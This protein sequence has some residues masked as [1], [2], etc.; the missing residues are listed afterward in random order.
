[1]KDSVDYAITAHPSI[2]VGKKPVAVFLGDERVPVKKWT[3]VYTVILQRCAQD[4][5]YYERL[6][7]F[8]NKLAGKIRVFIS[9]KPDGMTRQV[10][11]CDGLYGETHYG[12]QTLMH[13][14]VNIILKA[15]RYD[16]STIRVEVRISMSTG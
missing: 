8:R 3:S 1:M 5:I 7:Y 6:M 10:E 9:N 2:F 13:I 15:I 11:I 14:L 4:Q 16:T 12:S